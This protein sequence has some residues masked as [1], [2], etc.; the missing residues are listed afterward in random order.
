M[1]PSLLE[2]F[3]VTELFAFLLIFCRMGAGIMMLP[4]IAEAYVST[5][6]RLHFALAASLLLVPVFGDLMPEVP[7]SPLTLLI[8]VVAEIVVGFFIGFLA[9]L[10][11][12][13]MHIAGTIIAYQSSLAMATIFDISLGGQSTVIGNFMT[14]TAVVLF[15]TLDM[16]HIM[17]N[18]LADSYS[19]FPPGQFPVVGDMAEHLMQLFGKVFAMGFKLSAPHITFALL[20]Y[21]C[22]GVLSRLM[23][24][25]H[26]FFILMPIQ[27]LIAFFLLLA[28]FSSI[29]IYYTGFVED[30][31]RAFLNHDL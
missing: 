13:T 18:G 5:R 4:G 16:H 10:L 19:L 24:T 21:L 1:A 12:S 29:M 23:P 20:F 25:M 22:S 26:V 28:T 14:M 15:F 17:I 9:R 7:G 30:A 2:Q 6:M 3:L 31:L 8:L 27:I 11:V